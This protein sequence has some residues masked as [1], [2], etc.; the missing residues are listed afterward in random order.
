MLQIKYRKDALRKR[1]G[2]PEAGPAK[3]LE[4]VNV[5]SVES[6]DC[7]YDLHAVLCIGVENRL[8][9]LN[10]LF[11]VGQSVE[12]NAFGFQ[13]CN[14]V[15][16]IAIDAVQVVGNGFVPSGLMSS[17]PLITIQLLTSSLTGTCAWP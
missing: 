2:R 13:L 6:L 7:L 4:G 12:G 10:P 1:P 3:S 11:S 16:L 17:L 5:D 14:E 15:S 9:C 8:H